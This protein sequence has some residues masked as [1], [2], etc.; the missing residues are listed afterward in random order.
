MFSTSTTKKYSDAVSGVSNTSPRPD[1]EPIP[2]GI[3]HNKPRSFADVVKT[4]PPADS[5]PIDRR[6]KDTVGQRNPR[7]GSKVQSKSFLLEIKVPRKEMS[8]I[9]GKGGRN[10]DRIERKFGVKIQE[11]DG[12]RDPVAATLAISGPDRRNCE[13]AAKEIVSSFHAECPPRPEDDPWR[14]F[15]PPA[16][17]VALTSL[18]KRFLEE[19]R[20]CQKGPV[21]SFTISNNQMSPK[22]KED[23][24]GVT[25]EVQEAIDDIVDCLP[26][27][28]TIPMEK[29]RM[30][31]IIKAAGGFVRN[32]SNAHGSVKIH[33]TD[34]GSDNVGCLEIQGPAQ[35]CLAVFQMIGDLLDAVDLM[36]AKP[37]PWH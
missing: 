12:P 32:Q 14:G 22:S 2:G 16:R 11:R 21:F 27:T 15:T 4:N 10:V 23:S 18:H 25:M 37:M 34:E 29:R 6:N 19:Q 26:L 3:T 28:L 20:R 13:D 35:N 33:V 1:P 31:R 7:S 17:N 30:P 8:R 24:E 9:I 5:P 36:K